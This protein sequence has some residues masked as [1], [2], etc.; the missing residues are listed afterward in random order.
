M[1]A[2][3]ARGSWR[4]AAPP[5]VVGL[6]LL[7]FSLVWATVAFLTGGAAL[8][9][10]RDPDRSP[11]TDGLLAPADGKVSVV[12]EEDHRL[13][14]GIFMNLT[15]VHVN[16]APLTGTVEEVVHSPGKHWPAFTKE[17]DRNE[18]VRIEF[19]EYTVVLIA[20]AVARRIHPYVEP[21]ETVARGQRIG[22]ISF[23][24]RVDVLMP[25]DVRRDDLRVSK[26]ET[27]TAGE[28]R[29]VDR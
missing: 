15:D 24:S 25:E 19:E 9:F 7:P 6:F 18:K 17:S 16:R 10:H 4:Y 23:S 26:G 27:V 13:R 11:P 28:T 22:H 8:G 12:R 1:C 2:R 20:G 29:L 3:F 14:V 21:G 5:A